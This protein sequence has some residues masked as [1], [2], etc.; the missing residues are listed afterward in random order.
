MSAELIAGGCVE[1]SIRPA[2]MPR[3]GPVGASPRY[4]GGFWR[5]AGQDL[6]W[7]GGPT[8]VSWHGAITTADG[9]A[10][11]GWVDGANSCQA[12]VGQRGGF[13]QYK[14][15]SSA[16][17]GVASG[18]FK[19]VVTVETW[20]GLNPATAGYDDVNAAGWQPEQCERIADVIAWSWPALGIPIQRLRR[21]DSA[22]HGP[23]RTGISAPVTGIPGG[24]VYEGPDRWSSDIHKPCSGDVRLRQM[25]GPALD[26]G[27]GSILARARVIAT[28]VAAGRCDYLPPGDVDLAFAL[29]RTG[30][31]PPVG[32]D[33]WGQWWR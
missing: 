21:T 28:T 25:Y 13:W 27:D 5:P 7:N 10:I 19:G 32:S 29:A 15:F 31:A 8:S 24:N 6:G 3:R 16:A 17:Y 18:N 4:P 14:E 1:P 33:W 26:G 12:F 2:H 11:A 30:G 20:D 23:H 22:G 9:E